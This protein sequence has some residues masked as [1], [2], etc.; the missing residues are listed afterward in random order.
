LAI[1]AAALAAPALALAQESTSHVY[2][3]ATFGQDHW[4]PGCASGA[5]CDDTDRALRVLAGY[6]INKMFAA[7][8]GYHNLGKATSSTASV[9]AYAWEALAVAAWPVMGALSV[10][11]KLGIYRGKAEGGGALV[12]N[13]ETNYNGTWGFGAQFDA[14]R[15]VALRAEYQR[16]PSLAGGSLG[17]DSD[18]NVIS[19]GAIWRFQ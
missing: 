18:V 19:A 13:K 5:D 6:Q 2:V 15:N 12:P 11:G 8:V 9:K 4:R 7:E 10:Y 3:G 14:T 17:P 1:A 16:Y